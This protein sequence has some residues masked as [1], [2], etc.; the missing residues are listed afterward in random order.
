VWT[1]KRYKVVA[2]DTPSGIAKHFGLQL[3]ELE[4]ANPTRA[5]EMASGKVVP[6]VVLNIPPP[7]V[8]THPPAPSPTATD[9]IA[10]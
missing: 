9:A 5:A 10:P 1:Y 2:G 8:L 4:L 3:W 7:G 6:N